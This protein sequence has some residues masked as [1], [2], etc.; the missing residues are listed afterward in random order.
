[1]SEATIRRYWDKELYKGEALNRGKKSRKNE[2]EEWYSEHPEA[3]VNDCVEALKC[4][5]STAKKYLKEEQGKAAEE[6]IAEIMPAEATEVTVTV[7][8]SLNSFSNTAEAVSTLTAAIDAINDVEMLSLL[9]DLISN[10]EEK[11][12]TQH[13]MLARAVKLQNNKF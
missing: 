7:N 3:G 5:K 8:N 4:S 9:K 12:A 10:K 6:K 1:M 11:I 13:K 2:I